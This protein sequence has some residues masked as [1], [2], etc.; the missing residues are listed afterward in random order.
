MQET[1]I[2]ETI[3]FKP[4]FTKSEY[5][6]S[7]AWGASSFITLYGCDPAM[8]KSFQDIHDFSVALCKAIDMKK[9]GSPMIERFAEGYYEGCSLL[10]FIE[11]S[12]ITAHFDEQENRA[13]ID[14]FS[15]KYFNGEEA[16]DFCKNF[17]KADSYEVGTVIR[18]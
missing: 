15:C 3:N 10:Q 1:K 5:K 16:A 9:Y 18:K 6:K 13:F 12:S 2:I 17:F 7:K 14:I 11:T 8:I 4:S